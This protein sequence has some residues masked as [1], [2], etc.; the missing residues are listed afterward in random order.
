M[1]A[2]TAEAASHVETT[3]TQLLQQYTILAQVHI[4]IHQP[5][6]C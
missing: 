6:T 3:L 5:P 1:S 4:S 2:G